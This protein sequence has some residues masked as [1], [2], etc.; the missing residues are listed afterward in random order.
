VLRKFWYERTIRAKVLIAIA[1]INLLAAG[2]AGVIAVINAREATRI[3]MEASL[4]VAKR[5]VRATIQGLS[6]DGKVES[7]SKRINQLTSRLRLAQL[8]HVR[9]SIADAS[10]QLVSVQERR[11]ANQLPRAPAWFASLVEPHVASQQ[12]SIAVATS[13]DSTFILEQPV[14]AVPKVWN[15]GT[16]VLA[17]EPAD[18]IAEVWHDVS[19]LAIVWLGIDVLILAVL[20]LVLGRMLDPL[21]KLAR[22]MM[23]LEDGHYATRLAQPKVQELAAI[24]ERFNYLAEAL[25]RARAENAHLY[26]QLIM[27]QEEERREIANEIHD[28]ASPCL[29]GIT[30]NALSVQRLT[31]TRSDR[32]TVEMRGHIAEILKVTERL[33]LMN[34][35]LLKRLRPVALGRV[36]L[37]D[38][39][40]DLCREMQRRYPKVTITPSIKAR[41]ASYGETIDLTLYRC[42]QEGVTNAIRHGKAGT[43]RVEIFEKRR[44][45]GEGKFKAGPAL[46]LTI[47]DDGQG[48]DAGTPAGFG[49]TVMR[50]RIHALGGSFIIESAPARGTTLL[51]ILPILNLAAEG[52]DQKEGIPVS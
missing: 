34:R 6:P 14:E 43:V 5:F 23:R 40:E 27:V 20:F 30:A 33:N 9:I 39:V 48:I 49:L 41:M 38:L 7:L 22:G 24:S 1:V 19:A 35:M 10:G 12:L 44:A 4:E 50:E 46:H 26:G 8:R 42:V 15:L 32:K 18:E 28:E 45:R 37:V 25:D 29:F 21:A 47:Q 52:A 17:G 2:L 11:P 51:I 16:V 36:A 31:G 13:G 3:E